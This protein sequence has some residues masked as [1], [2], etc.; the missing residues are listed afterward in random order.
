M[1][2]VLI[3][4][5]AVITTHRAEAARLRGQS[6]VDHVCKVRVGLGHSNSPYFSV[7]GYGGSS[8]GRGLLPAPGDRRI[9]A[10]SS[11]RVSGRWG[12]QGTK[13]RVQFSVAISTVS[14]PTGPRGQRARSE[15]AP[16]VQ[17]AHR[18]IHH[19]SAEREV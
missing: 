3:T 12:L 11:L 17:Q 4:P 14:G 16:G 18:D 7:S 13:S 9:F 1:V 19:G 5:S 8:P 6:D 2:I 10:S 15:T